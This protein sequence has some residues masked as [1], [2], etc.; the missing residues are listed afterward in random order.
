M[1]Y[2]WYLLKNCVVMSL[3]KATQ[4]SS[5]CFDLQVV[6]HCLW[7][8]QLF[9][10]H[11]YLICQIWEWSFVHV[12][13]KWHPYS[14]YAI[15]LVIKIL[16]KAYATKGNGWVIPRACSSIVISLLFHSPDMNRNRKYDVQTLPWILYPK[17]YVG[18]IKI[19]IWKHIWT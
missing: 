4:M 13:W 17:C 11:S 7:M 5:V 15:F 3:C 8:L 18:P 19:V 1:I 9:L 14:S 12:N 16:S 6:M 2:N 10:H